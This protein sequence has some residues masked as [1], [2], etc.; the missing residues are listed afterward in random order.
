MLHTSEI[1]IKFI[2]T[3]KN[4]FPFNRFAT[5]AKQVKNKPVVNEVISDSVALKRMTK[6]IST[7]EEQL[8]EKENK[9]RTLKGGLF[10]YQ[11]AETLPKLKNRRRTW[12]F[13][14][15][16]FEDVN[17]VQS[18]ASDHK[19]GFASP[20]PKSIFGQAVEY[21]D[22]E[23]ELF[24]NASILSDNRT[25]G[26]LRLYPPTP[27]LHLARPKLL[28]S[29]PSLLKTPKSVR[30]MLNNEQ[31]PTTSAALASPMGIDKDSRIKAIEEELEELRHFHQS[32]NL[33]HN[34]VSKEFD[35]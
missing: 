31:P 35:E 23:F 10:N 28:R 17:S 8:T 1:P 32:E 12:A 29:K 9:L 16:S 15:K 3:K 21:T 7:L 26:Q 5:R 25:D 22:E 2:F 19:N 27:S 24:M 20:I 34:E 14:L 13:S 33:V 4:C 18:T 11:R 30:R 6:Q